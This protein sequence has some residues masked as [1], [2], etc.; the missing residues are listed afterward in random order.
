[1]PWRLQLL[2]RSWEDSRKDH[3]GY[4]GQRLQLSPHGTDG[5]YTVRAVT[6]PDRETGR[7][8][9]HSRVRSG[10]CR[11]RSRRRLCSRVDRPPEEDQGRRGLGRQSGEGHASRSSGSPEEESGV[12]GKDEKEEKP[13]GEK[14]REKSPKKKKKKKKD[15]KEKDK[16]DDSNPKASGSK[17]K[18]EKKKKKDSGSDDEEESSSSSNKKVKN[19]YK[20]REAC[21]KRAMDLYRGTGVDPREKIRSRIAKKARKYLKKKSAPTSSSDSGESSGSSSC[22]PWGL[23]EETIFGQPNKVLALAE[24]FP[25]VLANQGMQHMRGHGCEREP[26]GGLCNGLP[27]AALGSQSLGTHLSGAL[28]PCVHSRCIGAGQTSGCPRH[29]YPT[30]EE[31]REHV[32]RSSLDDRPKVRSSSPRRSRN[33]PRRGDFGGSEGCLRRGQARVEFGS[34][35]RKGPERSPQGTRKE[36]TRERTRQRQ[37]REAEGQSGNKGDASKKKD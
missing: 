21:K 35:R 33:D 34:P 2:S 11:D 14:E 32:G 8:N 24:Q 23:E 16:D 3:R 18:K 5:N 13:K 26:V 31:H 25:G 6:I 36:P 27:E 30:D 7:D 4:P 15:K 20:P 37:A 12:P 10:L 19:G 1:M 28:D 17:A 22:G 29:S 9:P